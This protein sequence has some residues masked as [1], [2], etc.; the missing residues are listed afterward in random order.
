MKEP[1]GGVKLTGAL[2][3][4]TRGGR[5]SRNEWLGIFLDKLV[6]TREDGQA[7]HQCYCCC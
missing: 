4:S 6:K 2:R 1:H 3:N 7:I 5:F